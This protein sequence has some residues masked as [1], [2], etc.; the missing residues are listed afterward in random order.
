MNI[1]EYQ[2]KALLKDVWRAGRRRPCRRNAARGRRAR[3]ELWRRDLRGEG[4]D[5]C[6]RHGARAAASSWSRRSRSCHA[7]ADRML[8]KTLVTPQTGPKGRLVRRVYVVKDATIARELYLVAAGRSRH[9]PRRLRRLDRGRRGYRGGG[10]RH[11]GEDRHAYRR[12]GL[13][14][15]APFMAA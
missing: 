6:R 7:E 10:R 8:G 2:A 5:P 15:R 4:A 1:H 11:A 13:G 9:W 14:H 12:S 3:R